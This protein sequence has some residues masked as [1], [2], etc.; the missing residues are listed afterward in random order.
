M[1]ERQCPEGGVWLVTPQEARDGLTSTIGRSGCGPAAIH[2]VLALLK[3]E[4]LPTPE[5]ILESSPARQRDYDAPLRQYLWSRAKA[6]MTHEGMIQ[7]VK[8]HSPAAQ[9]LFFAVD[10]LTPES[11]LLSWLQTWLEQGAVP[12]VTVNNFLTGQDA[13]HH[14]VPAVPR[15]NEIRTRFPQGHRGHVSTA[16][17]QAR[18]R[19]QHNYRSHNVFNRCKIIDWPSV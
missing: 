16:F 3:V 14:Q 2:N 19:S 12:V 13:W 9:G 15:Q 5:E 18:S 8:A 1:A 6:G 11:A 17:A 10:K 7:G 4:P